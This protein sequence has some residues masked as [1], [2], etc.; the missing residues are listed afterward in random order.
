MLESLDVRPLRG[1][2]LSGLAGRASVEETDEPTRGRTVAGQ[3]ATDRGGG[4]AE[5]LGQ[6]RGGQAGLEPQTLE[7]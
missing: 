4:D 6:L 7:R 3:P 1:L 5:L 2:D